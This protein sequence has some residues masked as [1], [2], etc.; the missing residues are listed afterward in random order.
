MG[1]FSNSHDLPVT[2]NAERFG[3]VHARDLK[4]ERLGEMVSRRPGAIVHS[5]P[6]GECSD[7]FRDCSS[8][9]DLSRRVQ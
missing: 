6:E 5:Q 9:C 3:A 7:S 1:C 8:G 2:N 4:P